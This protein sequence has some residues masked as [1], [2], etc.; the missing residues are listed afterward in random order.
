[1]NIKKLTHLIRN[2]ATTIVVFGNARLLR[3]RAGRV[4]LHGGTRDDRRAA[5]EWCSMFLHG[6]LITP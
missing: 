6:A 1:M 4:T 3:D 5:A 2:D